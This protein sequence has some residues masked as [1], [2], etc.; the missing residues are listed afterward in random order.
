MLLITA[1]GPLWGRT[2]GL[3]GSL[4]G[5]PYD[6]FALPDGLP[7]WLEWSLHC[8]GSS[9]VAKS[10]FDSGNLF[11]EAEFCWMMIWRTRENV[12]MPAMTGVRWWVQEIAW[13][14]RLAISW[15]CYRHNVDDDDDNDAWQ[16]ADYDTGTKLITMTLLVKMWKCH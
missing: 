8:Q 5:N 7:R 12:K 3:C 13:P 10:V 16:S 2:A 15:F 1:D 9:I 11:F 6:D 4:N 14:I